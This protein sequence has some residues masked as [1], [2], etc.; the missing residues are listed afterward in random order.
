MEVDES[1]RT[2]VVRN[3]EEVEGDGGIKTKNEVNE[4]MKTT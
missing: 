1:H 2:L 3:V 4:T